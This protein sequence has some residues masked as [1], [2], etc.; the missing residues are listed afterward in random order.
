MDKL[1][2]EE[3]EPRFL[4]SC[5]SGFL[6]PPLPAPFVAG[7]L[8]IRVGE[9][10]PLMVYVD[11]A[12]FF[13]AGKCVEDEPEFGIGEH[14]SFPSFNGKGPAAPPLFA[15][16]SPVSL[17]GLPDKLVNGA[18]EVRAD[19]ADQGPNTVVDPGNAATFARVVQLTPPELTGNNYRVFEVPGDTVS[20]I[21]SD[22]PLGEPL[23][24][25]DDSPAHVPGRAEGQGEAPAPRVF[26]LVTSLP[27]MDL[28]SLELGM[29]QFLE[30]VDDL[31]QRIQDTSGPGLYPW[32]V[33]V[34]AAA[35]ACEIARRQLKQPAGEP[36]TTASTPTGFAPDEPFAG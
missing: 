31:G 14:Y 35:V 21:P 16:I 13:G 32:I 12:D 27:R 20:Q 2:I 25:L 24:P 30:Q 6:P 10:F 9:P 23:P 3:L 1:R 17:A 26:D 18:S 7:T 36:I 5:T 11:H 28:S 33:S 4:F 15:A 8:V 29:R 22:T 19:R 34:A